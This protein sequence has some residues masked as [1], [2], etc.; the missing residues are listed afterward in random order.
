ME[1]QDKNIKEKLD[2]EPAI[3]I[4]QLKSPLSSIKLSLQMFL[5]GSFGK[6]TKEQKEIIEK[7]YQKN[8]SLLSFVNDLSDINNIEQKFY[9]FNWALID[10]QDI[11]QTI[12][13][14]RKEDIKFKKIKLK[15]DKPKTTLPKIPLDKEKIC[16]VIENILDN[17]VKYNKIGGSV[18]ISFG[19]TED[20]VEVRFK[21]SGIGIPDNEQDKLFSKFFR[22]SNAKKLDSNGSGLGLFIAKNIIELHNGKIWFESKENKGSTFFVALPVKLQA[23]S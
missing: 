7:I 9:S 15:I 6:I 20:F 19:K 10:L 3:L 14:L 8:N 17:A 4:H 13:Y 22:A 12:V 16:M 23:I 5:D 1:E 18:E 2:I 11:I 21:D